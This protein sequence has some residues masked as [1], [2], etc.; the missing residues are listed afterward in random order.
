METE[1]L[2]ELCL[3]MLSSTENKEV[4]YTNTIVSNFTSLQQNSITNKQILC[5]ST[6]QGDEREEIKKFLMAIMKEKII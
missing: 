4:E 3:K 2:A 6:F 5:V 1:K